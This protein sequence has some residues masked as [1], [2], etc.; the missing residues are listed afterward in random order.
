[1]GWVKEVRRGEWK[2]CVGEGGEGRWSGSSNNNS[3]M[4]VRSDSWGIKLNEIVI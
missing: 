4:H 3:T 2:G 1:M